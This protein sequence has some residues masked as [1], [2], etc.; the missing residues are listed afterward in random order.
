[1]ASWVDDSPL[2]GL[3]GHAAYALLFH[4]ASDAGLGDYRASATA[5]VERACVALAETGMGASLHAGFSGIAWVVQH[6]SGAPPAEED[7]L[8]DIDALL[9]DHVARAPFPGTA[10][11]LF[12][13]GVYALERLPVAAARRMLEHIVARLDDMADRFEDGVA[14]QTGP[15]QPGA[16]TIHSLGVSHGIPGI[17]TVLAG[18][19]AWGIA[20]ASPLLELGR[21]WL[22]KQR[23]PTAGI[24]FSYWLED[25]RRANRQWPAWCTGD[26][27]VAGALLA[28]ARATGSKVDEARAVGLGL[29]ALQWSPARLQAL[30][31]D[32]L[33]QLFGEPDLIPAFANNPFLCHGAAGR[34]HICNRLFQATGDERF[35]RAAIAWLESTLSLRRPGRRFGGFSR[36]LTEDTNW[37]ES[38]LVFGAAGVGLALLAAATSIEPRWDRLLMLSLALPR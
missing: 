19:A 33:L 8:E 34:L 18:A 15:A 26:P 13:I 9:V 20:G 35:A 12:G 25:G 28:A 2:P 6:L 5:C 21:E 1:V 11:E 24:Q 36:E 17:L 32:A 27:G 23:D 4:Y 30:S 14:W 29:H 7:A 37:T 3:L 22:W 10:E 16:K 31:A 38:G